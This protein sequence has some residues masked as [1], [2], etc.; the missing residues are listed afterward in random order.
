[1]VASLILILQLMSNYNPSNARDKD[2]G[3]L[4]ALD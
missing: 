4:K 3:L 1:M 2:T